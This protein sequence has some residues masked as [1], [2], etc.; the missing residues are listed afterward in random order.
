M[1]SMA[2]P[3]S[4]VCSTR[5]VLCC[6]LACVLWLGPRAVGALRLVFQGDTPGGWVRFGYV[7]VTAAALSGQM[8]QA[9]WPLVGAQHGGCLMRA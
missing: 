7:L 3:G 9:T 6:G 4:P 8:C 1:R 5:E 2:H